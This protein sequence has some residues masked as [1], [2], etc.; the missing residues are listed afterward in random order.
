MATFP[1][2]SKSKKSNVDVY[3]YD[4]IPLKLKNQIFHTINDYLSQKNYSREDRQS[5]ISVV[6][7]EICKE[8]G[9]KRLENNV[10]GTMNR[11]EEIQFFFDSLSD[12]DEVLDV[13]VIFLY[14]LKEL[15]KAAHSSSHFFHLNYTANKAYED[16]NARFKENGIGYQYLNGKIIKIDNQLLHADIIAPV[17]LL[18][19]GQEYE[20]INDEYIKAHEHFRFH[21]NQ[22]CLN[23]CLKS[24]ETTMKIICTKNNWSYDKNDT[25]KKLINILLTNK[26]LPMYQETFLS[27]L[28]Q[29]L[30]SS[31]PTIRNKNSAH[32]Q[33]TEKKF[34]S[35]EVASFMLN[36][37]GST[38]KFLIETQAASNK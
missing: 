30:E 7:K 28:R 3:V 6:Y 20:N 14:Y 13:V 8:F 12:V 27:T 5:I 35:N 33:G 2:Y 24:F 10:L 15:E 4:D 18:L 16:I 31:I 37:T 36:M 26:F 9:L 38:I 23:E 34:V 32:G 17:L 11:F 19:T 25:S 1:T 29:L 21:R 22:E